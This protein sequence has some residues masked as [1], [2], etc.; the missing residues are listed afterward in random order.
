MKL[1]TK[2]NVILLIIIILS[3]IIGY[4]INEILDNR[5][6][7]K[8]NIQAAHTNLEYERN[9]EDILIKDV[10][11]LAGTGASMRPTFYTNNRLLVKDYKNPEELKEG[12]LITHRLKAIQLEN[13][14]LQG[15]NARYEEIIK[16]NQIEKIVVGVLYT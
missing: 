16:F 14:V 8:N 9:D 1:K 2:M 13:L 15:D 3:S 11:V 12:Q 6:F 5:L 4:G 10:E 7:L